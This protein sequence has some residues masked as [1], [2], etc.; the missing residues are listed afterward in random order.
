MLL[1]LLNFVVRLV[2]VLLFIKYSVIYFHRRTDLASGG[3]SSWL[4]KQFFL[5]FLISFGF[6]NLLRLFLTLLGTRCF[7]FD[8][9]LC[10]I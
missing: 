3:D 7:Y 10:L 4:F 2:I 5:I 1:T 9:L 6:G 8:D